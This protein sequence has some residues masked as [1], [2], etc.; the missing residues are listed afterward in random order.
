MKF[1]LS[2]GSTV[3]QQ[4]SR[5]SPN[6]LHLISH[7]KTLSIHRWS[8]PNQS[9]CPSKPRTLLPAET[10][11]SSLLRPFSFN[12]P[13][14]ESTHGPTLHYQLFHDIHHPLQSP[15][16]RTCCPW[17]PWRPKNLSELWLFPQGP[18]IMCTRPQSGVLQLL[19]AWHPLGLTA[20]HLI[21]WGAQSNFPCSRPEHWAR[22]GTPLLTHS[23]S[24]WFYRIPKFIHVRL[25]LWLNEDCN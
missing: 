6:K 1:L 17:I 21:A 22:H 18:Q 20:W 23:S 13:G 2:L 4:W 24:K 16:A 10:N 14:P 9:A 5:S 19:T 3:L 12:S 8:L 15:R 7:R 11:Q 25:S